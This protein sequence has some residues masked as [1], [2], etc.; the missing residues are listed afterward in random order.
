M[1]KLIIFFLFS[2]F[3]VFCKNS[4][5]VTYS[6]DDINKARLIFT[7][8]VRSPYEK[9]LIDRLEDVMWCGG[10]SLV[11]NGFALQLKLNISREEW[12]NMDLPDIY[13]YI[14]QHDI[15][16]SNK[17][18]LDTITF[19]KKIVMDG[20]LSQQSEFVSRKESRHFE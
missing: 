3:L 15:A 7:T 12:K 9:A 19:N 5:H 8:P 20:F 10:L 18:L 1:K 4:D 2:V 11:D 17:G 16:C 13:Y 14:Y 6:E